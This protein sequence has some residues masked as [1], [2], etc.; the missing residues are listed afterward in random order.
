MDCVH[1][2]EGDGLARCRL[3]DVGDGDGGRVVSLQI[4]KSRLCSTSIITKIVGRYLCEERRPPH[5]DPVVLHKHG[6]EA[7][8]RGDELGLEAVLHVAAHLHGDVLVRTCKYAGHSIVAE[9][10]CA[11]MNTFFARSV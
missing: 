2:C 8:L 4:T 10:I 9:C 7:D 11:A 3:W 6:V 1:T 5:G